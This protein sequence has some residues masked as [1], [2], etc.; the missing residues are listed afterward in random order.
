MLTVLSGLPLTCVL[1]N[2]SL[3]YLPTE[4]Q[5][6]HAQDLQPYLLQ[7]LRRGTSYQPATKVSQ[8]Q[9]AI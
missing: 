1:A 7:G 5:E 8:L 3:F 6:F 2:R 4:P 9:Q